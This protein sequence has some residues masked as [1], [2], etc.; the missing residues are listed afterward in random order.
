MRQAITLQQL[1][2]LTAANIHLIDVRSEQEYANQHIPEAVNIPSEKLS[3]AAEKFPVDDTIVCICN[4]GGQRS[5]TAAENLYNHGF[6]NAYYLEGGTAGWFDRE[7]K[8]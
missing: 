5:Q 3:S 7:N 2:Q 1:E 6:R 4:H 8:K